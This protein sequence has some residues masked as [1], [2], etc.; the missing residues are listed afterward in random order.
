MQT[1][2]IQAEYERL[3]RENAALKEQLA[4][5]IGERNDYASEVWWMHDLMLNKSLSGNMVRV[6]VKTRDEVARGK[7]SGQARTDGCVRVYRDDISAG[8]GVAASTVS[9]LLKELDESGIL[10]VKHTYVYPDKSST[11]LPQKE[12]WLNVPLQTELNPDNIVLMEARNHGGA[13]QVRSEEHT[14]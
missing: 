14:A 7:V 12:L 3:K 1:S 6:L 4:F 10:E 13:R 9:R 8:S 11:G 2:N 5:T